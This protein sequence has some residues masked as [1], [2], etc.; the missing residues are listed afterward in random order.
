MSLDTQKTTSTAIGPP[1][2]PENKAA[3]HDSQNLYARQNTVLPARHGNAATSAL[4]QFFA[5]DVRAAILVVLVDLMVFGGDA[6]SFGLLIPLGIVVGGI[7]GFIVYKIQ[8]LWYHDEHD[9][10]LIKA[11]I[12]GLLTA[13]PVPLCPLIAIPGG[14]I[15]FVNMVRRKRSNSTRA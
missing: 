15:G 11:M 4:M 12:V 6:M 7:L 8:M 9:S 10:A 13:I 1:P 5:L 14:I 3:Q 2:L